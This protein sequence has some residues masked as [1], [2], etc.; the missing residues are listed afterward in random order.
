MWIWELIDHLNTVEGEWE[1]VVNDDSLIFNLTLV[2]K[3]P[4]EKEQILGRRDML[5][6]TLVYTKKPLG[7]QLRVSKDLEFSRAVDTTTAY[8]G[9]TT[10]KALPCAMEIDLSFFISIHSFFS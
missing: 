10:F 3:G 8:L 1:G 9:D 4:Q 7:Y 6:S 2:Y 5:K